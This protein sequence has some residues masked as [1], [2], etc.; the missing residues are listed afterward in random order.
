MAKELSD[1]EYTAREEKISNAEKEKETLLKE[2]E[3]LEGEINP[4]WR[5]FRKKEENLLKNLKDAGINIDEETG[6]LVGETK[7]SVEEVDKRAREM[8]RLESIAIRKDELLS[9]IEDEDGRK[10]V[11]KYFDKLTSGEEVNLKN[12]GSHFRAAVNAAGLNS[13]NG[14]MKIISGS[15]GQPPRRVEKKVEVLDD[16]TADNM[17]GQMGIGIKIKN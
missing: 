10:V 17:A 11:E 4:N 2:K 15:N 1:E 8:Y 14:I 7:V 9:E 6:E 13:D 5:K 12:I 3:A 16:E